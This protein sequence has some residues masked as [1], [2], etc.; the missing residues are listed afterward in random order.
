M[1]HSCESANRTLQEDRVHLVT[2]AAF[3]DLPTPQGYDISPVR[4]YEGLASFLFIRWAD[5]ST[6]WYPIRSYPYRRTNL[7]IHA[8]AI[9]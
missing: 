4:W 2:Q 5:L 9:A 7:H 6:S 1:G 3:G 8:H